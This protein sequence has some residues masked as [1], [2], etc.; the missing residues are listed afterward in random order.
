MYGPRHETTGPPEIGRACMVLPPQ[1]GGQEQD[2]QA[3]HEYD[4]PK[5]AG[6][7]RSL[8]SESGELIPRRV[9]LQLA[10]EESQDGN[11]DGQQ[12]RGGHKEGPEAQTKPRT[13]LSHESVPP[14]VVV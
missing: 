2:C 14:L 11:E 4:Q 10:S 3:E 5:T 6:T 8:S 7:H 13:L 1:V 12:H 9:R